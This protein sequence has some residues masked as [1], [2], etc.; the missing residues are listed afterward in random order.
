MRYSVAVVDA[1]CNERVLVAVVEAVRVGFCAVEV[2]VEEVAALEDA[3][4]GNVKEDVVLV[5]PCVVIVTVVLIAFDVEG[6]VDVALLD[7][8][9]PESIEDASE[10]AGVEDASEP[11]L[12]TVL[13]LLDVVASVVV[14]TV[15]VL[16]PARNDEL[17]VALLDVAVVLP[18][19]SAVDASE[20][21]GVDDE[22]VS[23]VDVA[24]SG[25]LVAVASAMATVAPKN[26]LAMM[27]LRAEVMILLY[28]CWVYLMGLIMTLTTATSCDY[29]R[30]SE[31]ICRLGFISTSASRIFEKF[32]SSDSFPPALTIFFLP[33]GRTY[34]TV[35]TVN[36]PSIIPLAPR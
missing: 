29:L 26:R 20:N 31:G 12:E 19:E 30:N 32:A 11:A 3:K 4:S 33:F 6:I 35:I 25:V 13:V 27:M 24:A 16:F 34:V 9:V 2:L 14:P 17:D 36:P 1:D 15:E 23:V 21:R 10:K 8:A 5:L 22:T 7:V 28:I 18:S